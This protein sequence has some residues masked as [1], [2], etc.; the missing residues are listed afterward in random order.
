MERSLAW[1]RAPVFRCAE[2]ALAEGCVFQ[3]LAIFTYIFIRK[4][5]GLN[6]SVI[7]KRF[8]EFLK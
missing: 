8:D 5:D 7:S 4:A 3:Q 1:H 2:V 6:D